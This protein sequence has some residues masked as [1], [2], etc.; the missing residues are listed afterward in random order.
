MRPKSIK[1]I[2]PHEL[3]ILWDDGHETVYSLQRLRDHCPCAGCAGESVLLHHYEAPVPE[4][5]TPGRYELKSVQPD[6]S[7][8]VQMTWGDGHATGIYTFEYLDNLPT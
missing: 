4:R 2:N 7:Y 1:K 6:G 5:S 3:R 8:A